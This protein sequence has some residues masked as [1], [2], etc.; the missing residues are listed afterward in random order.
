MKKFS[1]ASLIVT[2][3]VAVTFLFWAYDAVFTNAGNFFSAS[4]P[5]QLI[6]YGRL[7][8]LLCVLLIFFQMLSNGRGRRL[9][10]FFPKAKLVGWHRH[11]GWMVLGLFLIHAGLVTTGNALQLEES[12]FQTLKTWL[13]EGS[14]FSLA[15]VGGILFLAAFATTWLWTRK[16]ISFPNW[17]RTHIWMAGA[18]LLVAGHMFFAWDASMNRA[19]MIF[20]IALTALVVLEYGSWK[21][22]SAFIANVRSN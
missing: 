18:F 4:L 6:H 15:A 10:K 13:T 22:R 17:K 8:G 16:K 20:W 12:P 2:A 1:T 5:T 3:I 14:I 7:A 9:E 21:I 11:G 19:F